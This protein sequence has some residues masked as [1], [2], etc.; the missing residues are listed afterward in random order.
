MTRGRVSVL[1]WDAQANTGK[2]IMI[3]DSQA[4]EAGNR[5]WGKQGDNGGC[6][7]TIDYRATYG[8]K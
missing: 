2:Y 5:E 4:K 1:C 3:L 6:G 7:C 8:D